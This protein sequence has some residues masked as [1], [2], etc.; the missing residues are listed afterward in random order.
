MIEKDLQCLCI[1]YLPNVGISSE[2]QEVIRFRWY[3]SIDVNAWVYIFM[4]SFEISIEFKAI[5]FHISHALTKF[6]VNIFTWFLICS[7]YMADLLSKLFQ[8]FSRKVLWRLD[9]F[10]ITFFVASKYSTWRFESDWAYWGW[11]FAISFV[12][13][14]TR[15]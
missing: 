3:D 14:I 2:F 9:T 7:V 4:F 12:I 8:L 6:S 15:F 10:W 1:A 5:W 11:T 13:S